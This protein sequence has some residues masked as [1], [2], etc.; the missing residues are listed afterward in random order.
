MKKGGSVFWYSY[1]FTFIVAWLVFLKDNH[2][3]NIIYCRNFPL[4]TD[5]QSFQLGAYF[6]WNFWWIWQETTH[7]VHDFLE[8]SLTLLTSQPG[9]KYIWMASQPVNACI[10]WDE[11]K[12]LFLRY[13]T[14]LDTYFSKSH[15]EYHLYFTL[16]LT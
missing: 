12:L 3:L 1:Y 13:D 11:L 6:S 10:V 8:L 15:L 16:H 2:S 14:I 5:I 4:P 9:K 7:T